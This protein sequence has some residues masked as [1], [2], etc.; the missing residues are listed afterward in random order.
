[1]NK[2]LATIPALML[3]LA[4][5]APAAISAARTE[6]ITPVASPPNFYGR[7][8]W[9]GRP[10][11]PDPKQALPI[12]LVVTHG[13][14]VV[15]KANLRTDASG[16]F[17]TLLETKERGTFEY[18]V[19]GPQYLAQAGTFDYD[20]REAVKLGIGLMLVGDVNDDNVV[21]NV[22][23]LILKKAFGTKEGD[24]GYDARAD[25][26]GDLGIDD[27]DASLLLDNLGQ[28]GK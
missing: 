2:R 14:T 27:D 21:D 5:I 16:L 28:T 8:V 26:N 18:R 17:S 24:V 25:L 7:V 1:V 4:L 15:L 20:G 3:S 6:D 11:M 9:Q 19:K 13:K 10:E 12:T 23:V 22:D